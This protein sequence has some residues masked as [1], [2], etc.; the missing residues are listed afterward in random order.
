MNYRRVRCQVQLRYASLYAVG[1]VLFVAPP[2]TPHVAHC[3]TLSCLCSALCRLPQCWVYCA[4]G[5][6][7]PDAARYCRVAARLAPAAGNPSTRGSGRASR[8]ILRHHLLAMLCHHGPRRRCRPCIRAC[9]VVCGGVTLGID[10]STVSAVHVRVWAAVQPL[11]AKFAAIQTLPS[12]LPTF[13]WGWR[14]DTPR[15]T[16]ASFLFVRQYH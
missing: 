3:I 4:L 11:R 5:M 9:A 16:R 7:P 15:H 6:I 14:K 13:R 12:P 8:D 1:Q 2:C 10:G